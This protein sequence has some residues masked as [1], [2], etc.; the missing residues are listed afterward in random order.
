MVG[1]RAKIRE[2]IEDVVIDYVNSEVERQI[3]ERALRGGSTVLDLDVQNTIDNLISEALDEALDD[4]IREIVS[5]Q[6]ED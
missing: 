6:L 1:I 3:D 4:E 2:Y 5:E